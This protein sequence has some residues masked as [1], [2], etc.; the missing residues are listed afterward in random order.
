MK[1]FH[2]RGRSG[3]D[4]PFPLPGATRLSE[5]DYWQD[6]LAEI[7]FI[8]KGPPT[9]WR[10]KFHEDLVGWFSFWGVAVAITVMTFVFGSISVALAFWS[11]KIAQQN[12]EVAQDALSLARQAVTSG[13]NIAAS[14]T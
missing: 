4:Y 2:F 3:H 13:A 6:R 11:I 7:Y 1:Q 5:F 14:S 9:T 12:L 10:Q 8:L